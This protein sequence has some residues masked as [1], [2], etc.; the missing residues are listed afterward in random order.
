MTWIDDI[1]AYLATNSTG[2]VGVDIAAGGF[3]PSAINCIALYNQ[4]GLPEKVTLGKGMQ[5]RRPE[6]GVRVRNKSDSLAA[7]NALAIHELLN[8]KVNT[9]IGTTRFKRIEA[10]AEPFFVSY[11]PNNKYIYSVNFRLEIG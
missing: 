11:D 6:L 10:V 2:T 8:L 1:A 3:I 5:L 7:S 9:V 4:T